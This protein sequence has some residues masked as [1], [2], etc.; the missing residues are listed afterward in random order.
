MTS[1]DQPPSDLAREVY[2]LLGIP[3]DVIEMPEVL[4]RI[5]SAA[6]A[7]RPYLVSTANLNFLS[8]SHKD[9]GFRETLLASDLCTAD[10]VPL[11][12]IAKLL[13]IPLR[14]RDRKSVV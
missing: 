3:I 8:A 14:S 5:R 11:I 1:P 4:S 12:W 7:S 10:G 9:F 6:R 13:G 2:G